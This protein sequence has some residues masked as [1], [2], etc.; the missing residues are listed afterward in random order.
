[1]LDRYW[2][3]PTSRISPEAPVPVV[4]IRKDETRPGGAANVALNLGSL[5]APASVLGVVGDDDADRLLG[6]QLQSRHMIAGCILVSDR[7]RAAE[8]KRVSDRIYIGEG[9]T[10]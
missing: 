10:L 9:T 2:I 8:V 1:M 7:K 3:G 5:G 4:R 6:Q